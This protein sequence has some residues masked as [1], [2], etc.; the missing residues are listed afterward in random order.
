MIAALKANSTANLKPRSSRLSQ[1]G[2]ASGL[3]V[4]AQEGSGTSPAPKTPLAPANDNT[5][6]EEGFDLLI[7]GGGATGTVVAVD[8]TTRGLNVAMVERDDFGAGTWADSLHLILY[9]LGIFNDSVPSAS[10]SSSKALAPLAELGPDVFLRVFWSYILLMRR[11]QAT[12]F[13]EPAGSHGVWGLDDYHLLPFLLGA[14]QLSDHPYLRP[15]PI[16]STDIISPPSKYPSEYMYLSQIALLHSIKTIPSSS[17]APSANSLR[18]HSPMLDDISSVKTWAQVEKGM[19]KMLEAEVVGNLPVAQHFL[20]GV[21]LLFPASDEDEVEIEESACGHTHQHQNT[22]VVRDAQGKALP[23]PTGHS[24]AHGGA[25]VVSNTV[26]APQQGGTTG[27]GDCCGIPI[28]SAY[29]AAAAAAAAA[30]TAEEAGSTSILTI[31]PVEGKNGGIAAETGQ[32]GRAKLRKGG[33]LLFVLG[34]DHTHDEGP[35]RATTIPAR[36]PHRHGRTEGTL[37]PS[38]SCVTSFSDDMRSGIP[39]PGGSNAAVWTTSMAE[40]ATRPHYDTLDALQSKAQFVGANTTFRCCPLVPAHLLT[41]KVAGTFPT[42]GAECARTCLHNLDGRPKNDCR[43]PSTPARTRSSHPPRR[44]DVSSTLHSYIRNN[45]STHMLF[46][47]DSGSAGEREHDGG[48][49]KLELT[50]VELGL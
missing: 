12:Y 8:A 37:R 13:L 47:L 7:V 43:R 29:G 4:I 30:A 26:D 32:L 36:A 20:F 39:G 45:L 25:D 2:Y 6:A 16:H 11:I 15:S 24:H 48:G 1:L 5:D 44:L 40:A 31:A 18:W 38:H 21:V 28:P 14:A 23:R 34:R 33:V 46:L 10:S 3:D 49:W 9:K 17:G 50:G 27:W 41:G 35:Q 19:W 22:T 42:P